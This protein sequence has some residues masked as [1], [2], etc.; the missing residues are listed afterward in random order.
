[1]ADETTTPVMNDVHDPLRMGRSLAQRPAATALTRLLGEDAP[2]LLW[3]LRPEGRLQGA[4][5]VDTDQDRLRAL[6]TWQ[7]IIGAGPV[8][9]TPE[10]DTEENHTI[11]GSYDG[12][13][14]KV[15]TV[16]RLPDLPALPLAEVM[17]RSPGLADAVHQDWP[18]PGAEP[19]PEL[20]P[21]AAALAEEFPELATEGPAEEPSAP[22]EAQSGRPRTVI[23]WAFFWVA[24]AATVSLVTLLAVGSDQVVKVGGAVLLVVMFVSGIVS[25]ATERSRGGHR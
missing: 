24:I 5:V 7:R 15:S 16:V 23:S 22:K 10:G 18:T 6:A 14:V 1:M 8:T 20:E 9:I 11:V 25:V 3:V 19:V 17:D 2:T 12:I 4:P 13:P 21:A